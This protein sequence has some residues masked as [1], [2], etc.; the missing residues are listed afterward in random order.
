MI[1]LKLFQDLWRS[2]NYIITYF[3]ME[4]LSNET[5]TSGCQSGWRST[6]VA[7]LS[8]DSVVSFA[9]SFIFLCVTKKG[10]CFK[11]IKL[12]Q[13]TFIYSCVV[14]EDNVWAECILTAQQYNS[15]VWCEIT[16]CYTDLLPALLL[17]PISGYLPF[18]IQYIITIL[19]YF[20]VRLQQTEQNQGNMKSI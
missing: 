10:M 18:T 6:W 12:F 11:V 4:Q 20:Y 2:K 13:F 9:V 19:L 7:V 14:P 15:H 5:I 17:F 3:S 1:A 16:Q 8:Q